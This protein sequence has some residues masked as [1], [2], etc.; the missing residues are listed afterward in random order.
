MEDLP[1]RN[2]TD[3]VKNCLFRLDKS[4]IWKREPS[5]TGWYAFRFQGSSPLEVTRI[6][7]CCVLAKIDAPY[8]LGFSVEHEA[9]GCVTKDQR[10]TEFWL[11][12]PINFN[13][14]LPY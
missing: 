8:N 5:V 14:C 3:G 6:V 12:G 11:S 4:P 7:W 13:L 2:P 1:K 10:Q 9:M